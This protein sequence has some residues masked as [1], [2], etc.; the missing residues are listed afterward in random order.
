MPDAV[1]R[2]QAVVVCTESLA[3]RDPVAWV[4]GFR[5][6]AGLD[7]TRTL[8][9]T[10]SACANFAAGLDVSH[11][12]IAAGTAAAVLL[13]VTDKVSAGTRYQPL[14]NSVVG[15]GAVSCLVTGSHGHAPFR[16]IGQAAETWLGSDSMLAH[17]RTLLTATRSAARRSTGDALVSV[18]HVI[19]PNFD[20]TT[21]QLLGMAVSAPAA[22]QHAGLLRE[23]GH[24]FSADVPLNLRDLVRSG[25]AVPGDL[26]LAVSC[27]KDTVYVTTFEYVGGGGE[28]R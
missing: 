8:L 27:S 3:G 22:A 10:G 21:R 26:V 11:G 14:G 15:D 25:A 7:T 28:D 16:L 18:R 5:A 19:T 1:G 17:A 13:V 23:V 24:C 12:L 9:V 2:F 6:A 4:R 20:E